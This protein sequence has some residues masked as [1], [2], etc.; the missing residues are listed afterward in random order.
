MKLRISW[1]VNI[2]SDI[3]SSILTVRKEQFENLWEYILRTL[4]FLGI[5]RMGIKSAH[6]LSLSI[7]SWESLKN[8]SLKFY[9]RYKRSTQ[10][11]CGSENIFIRRTFWPA[12]Y[13]NNIFLLD[14]SSIFWGSKPYV[15]NLTTWNIN[16]IIIDNYKINISI[17]LSP[18]RRGNNRKLRNLRRINR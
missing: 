7:F 11:N 1:N 6:T 16:L 5:N 9:P 4:K 18:N 13:V 17:Y 12:F 10:I 3:S 15:Y 14:I 2:A 8:S